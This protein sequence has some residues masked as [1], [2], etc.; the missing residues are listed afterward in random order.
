[1][2]G[3]ASQHDAEGRHLLVTLPGCARPSL[4]DVAAIERVV[5]RAAAAT[6]AHVLQVISHHF[7]PHGVTALALLAESHASLH[8]YPEAGVVFWDCFT[9]GA[10][11]DPRR[12]VAILVEALQ[13]QVIEEEE[14]ARSANPTHGPTRQAMP[15]G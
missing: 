1:M 14:I 12:S 8:T 7:E 15:A 3:T 11:C 6:G 4:D 13:P 2:P 10:E 5:R 9:C